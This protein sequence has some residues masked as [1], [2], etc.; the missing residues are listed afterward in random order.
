[1]EKSLL[2]WIK[3]VDKSGWEEVILRECVV[4]SILYVRGGR[5][6]RQRRNGDGV[7]GVSA[8]FPSMQLVQ[9]CPLLCP[10]PTPASIFALSALLALSSSDELW[11]PWL[12]EWAL[13]SNH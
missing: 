2:E 4:L 3:I 6:N 10:Q 12:M 1:M 7:G 5:I 9:S 11:A 8:A 13:S